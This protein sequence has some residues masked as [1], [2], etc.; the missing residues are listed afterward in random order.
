MQIIDLLNVQ[1]LMESLL[2]RK[3]PAKLAY[4]IA[5]NY[6]LIAVELEDYN[7]TRIK[8]LADNWKLDEKTNRYDIPD[9]DVG[10]WKNMHDEL[11]QTECGYQPYKIDIA[12]TEQT[13]WSPAELLALWFIF[14]GNGASD[15]APATSKKAE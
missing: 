4:G 9:A 1:P 5:K 10:K 2:E 14:E 12:L 11:L 13:D 8:L 7:K 15:L 6:R 3:M